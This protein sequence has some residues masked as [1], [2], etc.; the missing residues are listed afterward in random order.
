MAIKGSQQPL[1][2]EPGE[3]RHSRKGLAQP[4]ALSVPLASSV[5][6][7]G[8]WA[9]RV[10]SPA[11]F[12]C[13]AGLA[14]WALLVAERASLAGACRSVCRR[15]RPAPWESPAQPLHSPW[16]LS[17]CS[18][19]GYPGWH[20]SSSKL[21]WTAHPGNSK[22]KVK[23]QASPQ[24]HEALGRWLPT[25]LKSGP[26]PHSMGGLNFPGSEALGASS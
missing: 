24:T 1:H 18:P 9:I 15:P 7:W 22:N 10:A 23:G 25:A 6:K 12:R 14:R 11:T 3:Q 5:F 21:M 19:A 16:N 17:S 13:Q 26:E 20:S 8:S 4:P 2:L